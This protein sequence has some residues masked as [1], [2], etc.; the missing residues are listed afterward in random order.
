MNPEA[1]EWLRAARLESGLSQK[2]LARLAGMARTSIC[3]IER[4][5]HKPSEQAW[6]KI[7]LVL[8]VR[9]PDNA[10]SSHG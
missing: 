1:I 3:N 7:V 2:E 4:G 5:F 9:L 10:R 6:Q 8:R